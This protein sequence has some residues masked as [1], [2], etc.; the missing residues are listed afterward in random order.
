ME[1]SIM[2]D[3]LLAQG[4]GAGWDASRIVWVGVL[5]I[6]GLFALIFVLLFF[7][8]FNLWIQA[9]LTGANVGIP[10]MIGMTLRKVNVTMLVQQKIALTQ[11]GV[12]VENR[13][14]EAHYLARGNVPKTAAAVIAAYKAGIDLPWKTAA[15]IDLA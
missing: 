10:Y 15:A 3:I 8:Y 7:K 14:L 1:L 11:A 13:D 9:W 4:Q 12:R 2:H 6:V 5:A